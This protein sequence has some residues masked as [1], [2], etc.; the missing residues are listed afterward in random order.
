M[1]IIF[2][3]N[4][5][6]L[7]F[8]LNDTH[9]II[10]LVVSGIQILL[11][12]VALFCLPPPQKKAPVHPLPFLVLTTQKSTSLFPSSYPKS[13]LLPVPAIA[14]RVDS[15]L[16]PFSGSLD[17]FR[18]TYQR[19]VSAPNLAPILR[20]C[21]PGAVVWIQESSWPSW[22]DLLPQWRRSWSCS[23]GPRPRRWTG[24]QRP[25]RR[26]GTSPCSPYSSPSSPPSGSSSTDSSSR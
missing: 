23:W 11:L 16:H 7:E 20:Y 15:L 13:H 17:R 2:G 3:I 4:L 14:S 12:F 9:T 24:R 1:L 25:T 5:V 10:T 19:I 18:D 21:C 22:L 6:K 8:F 26:T